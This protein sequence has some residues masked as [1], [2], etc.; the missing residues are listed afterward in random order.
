MYS[1]WQNQFPYCLYKKNSFPNK[2]KLIAYHQRSKVD[3]H[4]LKTDL[5]VWTLSQ[6]T[7]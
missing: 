1:E 3:I 5:K 6:I 4:L 7:R 2:G